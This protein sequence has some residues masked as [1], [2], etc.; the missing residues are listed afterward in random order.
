MSGFQNDT[1]RKRYGRILSEMVLL[2]A[3][4]WHEL[5]SQQHTIIVSICTIPFKLKWFSEAF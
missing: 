2:E 5:V 1:I 4:E 3:L